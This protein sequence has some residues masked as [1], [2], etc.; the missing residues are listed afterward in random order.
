MR[1]DIPAP[2]GFWKDLRRYHG[3][4]MDRA[5]DAD[6]GWWLRSGESAWRM[7]E[8]PD[9]ASTVHDRMVTTQWEGRSRM[10]GLVI[11]GRLRLIQP[12][13]SSVRQAPHRSQKRSWYI[14][15]TWDLWAQ[16]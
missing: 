1:F 12:L 13:V 16:W 4:V 3:A 15:R 11:W 5:A 9:Q 2:P 6:G 8:E 7:V 14:T 10:G